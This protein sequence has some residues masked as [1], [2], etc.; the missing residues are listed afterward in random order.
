MSFLLDFLYEKGLGGSISN[1]DIRYIELCLK[2]TSKESDKIKAE[3]EMLEKKLDALIYFFEAEKAKYFEAVYW[4]GDT[5]VRYADS[6][7]GISGFSISPEDRKR[8]IGTFNAF[9]LQL[10]KRRS[11]INKCE[12]NFD[13]FRNI[14]DDITV[15]EKNILLFKLMLEYKEESI[16]KILTAET[17]TQK[18][19]KRASDATAS[20]MK[21]FDAL[22]NNDRLM[23]NLVRSISDGVD[24]Q[25]RGKDLNPAYVRER[26]A[27]F[28]EALK[29]KLT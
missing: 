7:A 19:K 21:L 27:V 16:A 17:N 10:D 11:E 2:E 26:C 5:V 25:H 1:E 24:S 12:F 14:S 20:F 9:M 29:R 6:F 18:L 22:K 4:I 8:C 3:L 13:F 28:L 15:L 23:N